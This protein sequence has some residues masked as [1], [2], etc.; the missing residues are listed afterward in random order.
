VAD[1]LVPVVV[2]AVD[3]NETLN[4]VD[5][6]ELLERVDVDALL[7]SVDVNALIERI[8]VNALLERVDIDKIVER[9]DVNALA[10][11]VEVGSLVGRGTE[12]ILKSFLDLLR[13][14]VVGLDV[15]VMR[16]VRTIDRREKDVVEGP[17]LLRGAAAGPAE[18]TGRY[19]GPVSRLVAF[20]L[21]VAV[22]LATFAGASAVVSFLIQLVSGYH[23]ART[24]GVGW[25]AALCVWAF[26]YLWGGLALAGRTVGKLLMGL[27]VVATDGSPLS[28]R[29]ALIR[30]LVLPFSIALFGIGLLLALVHRERRTLHDLASGTCVVYDW[31]DRPAEMPAP[32][33][34]WLSRRGAFGE[35][36]HQPS[37]A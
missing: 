30:V 4:R 17:P 12:G 8:D 18:V 33:S 3:L 1:A 26:L 20:A 9:V 7:R 24:E 6:N 35:R 21:D 14:Q 36:P 32:L 16:I 31:G 22:I 15:I 19:A 5:I 34:W 37:D 10:S 13:R 23:L 27:R 29:S 28:Q 25:I 11:R 2:D